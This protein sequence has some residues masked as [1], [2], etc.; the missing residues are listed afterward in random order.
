M[1]HSGNL[2]VEGCFVRFFLPLGG[3]L[4]IVLSICFGDVERPQLVIF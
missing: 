2:S 1:P 3:K 4:S